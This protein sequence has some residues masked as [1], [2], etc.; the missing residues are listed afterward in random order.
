MKPRTIPSVAP[1]ET[2]VLSESV[3]I[4][5]DVG[6]NAKLKITGSLE[7]KGRVK[8]GAE[9]IAS[10]NVSVK[11]AIGPD[12]IIKSE[13]ANVAAGCVIDDVS[14]QV[15]APGI[16]FIGARMTREDAKVLYGSHAYTLFGDAEPTAPV[17]STSRNTC[18][19]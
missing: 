9:V 8:S 19:P 14:I 7:V 11:T 2:L 10:G 13:N 12:T 6:V 17:K 4:T 3:I 15:Q 5:G 16:T 18:K 1:G